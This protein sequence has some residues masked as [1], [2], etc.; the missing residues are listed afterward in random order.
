MTYWVRKI[1]R[2]KWEPNRALGATAISADAIIGDLRTRDNRLSL[3]KCEDPGDPGELGKVV[4][5]I[6]SSGDRLDKIDI[7]WI[8]SREAIASGITIEETAGRT[9]LKEYA[10]K[11]LDTVNL[12]LE[13][14][15]TLARL[16]AASARGDKWRR[17]RAGE[18]RAL[19]REAVRVGEIAEADLPDKIKEA[20]QDGQ[21]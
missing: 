4:V 8:E 17:Y 9:A 3:W 13:K 15:S 7:V 10:N 21:D 18:V 2:A 14:L 19:I 20:I 1:S 16:V 12:D 5:A 11:H 6:A